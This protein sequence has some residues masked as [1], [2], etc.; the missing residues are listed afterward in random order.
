M[1]R[2]SGE[3]PYRARAYE[4]GADALDALE[5]DVAAL[6]SEGRLTDVP[7]IGPSLAATITELLHTGAAEALE[8]IA[9]DLPVGLLEVAHVPGMTLRRLRLLHEALDIQNVHDLRRAIDAGAVEA[10]KGFGAQTVARLREGL[11]Q[12]RR[13]PEPVLLVDALGTAQ[14]LC[15]HLRDSAGVVA[16]DVVGSVRRWADT[17][18]DINLVAASAEAGAALDALAAHPSVARTAVPAALARRDEV[19]C[20][21]RLFD[22]MGVTLHVVSPARYA[23]AVALGTASAE[24]RRQLA[25]R[26]EVRG[27][28]LG[29]IE[30]D[31]EAA[32]YARL[33]LPL[34]PAELRE[35]RGEL[36]EVDG[37][38]D[39]ADLLS[40][41]DIQG[42]VHCH[43]TYSDGGNTV[44]E[45]ARAAES[46]GMRY[47]TI[48]DHSPTASY[49]GGV[50]AE[51]L[52]EQWREIAAAQA[53]TPVRILRGTESDILRDGE[54][55]YPDAL[56][57][58]LDV[59]IAS[60]HNRYK[61]DAGAMTERLSRAMERPVFKIWGHPLGRLLLRREPIACD[62]E[63]ILDVVA[64]SPAAI[65]INGSPHRLDL[66]APWARAARQRGIK[67]VISTD[68]HSTAEVD[69]L[70]FGVAVARRAGLRRRDVL[71]ALPAA[72]FAAAV[73]PMAPA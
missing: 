34:I 39:F 40:I 23:V 61:L 7:G 71:N 47:L 16:A 60:I 26:A 45:M 27:I 67:F 6:A 5:G 9:G 12:Q 53:N 32:F 20:E 29:T 1:L 72:A 19:V 51:R 2:L 63:R 18:R 43:T 13:G 17:V 22:G 8:R 38:D 65:E 4:T 54:L 14:R 66:P 25:A 56:L 10:L 69:H 59:V 15:A 48:T 41:G 31:S 58:S 21:A 11:E 36:E 62:V 55:D 64:K 33:G 3:N 44:A 70:K 52:P 68:A 35:G 73:R 28:E 50:T 37:G 49:A 46:R 24:H 30:A 42:M 57:G